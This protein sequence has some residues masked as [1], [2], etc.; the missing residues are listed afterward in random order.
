MSPGVMKKNIPKYYYNNIIL[1]AAL[2]RFV[3]I[4]LKIIFNQRL[5]K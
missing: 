5:L 3:D 2:L 4:S 1:C